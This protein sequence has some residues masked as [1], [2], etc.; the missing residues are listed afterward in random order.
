MKKDNKFKIFFNKLK[1]AWKNPRKKAGIKLLGYFLFFVVF[2]SIAAIANSINKID[3]T[4]DKVNNETKEEID[5]NNYISKQ[6]NL[7]NN[8]HSITS[9]IKINDYE[10]NVN[11][12]IDNNIV[13]GYLESI[14]GIKKIVI[15]DNNIYEIVN[16]EEI[17]LDSVI[18]G[19]LYNLEYIFNL[20]KN[21]NAIINNKDSYKDY[22]YF[23]N[24]DN[25][26]LN[27]KVYTD[28]NNIYKIEYLID[29]DEY[30]L[31]FDK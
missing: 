3:K 7:L 13:N 4:I 30:V 6:N 12:Y 28:S 18:N 25:Y 10:Y 19:N 31:N 27:T 29:N 1:E 22:S 9:T 16:N 20:L 11:G 17:L 26:V 14:D 23:I 8:K 15:K 24:M 5:Y 2:L 21:N